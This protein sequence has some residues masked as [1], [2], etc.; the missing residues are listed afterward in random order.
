MTRQYDAWPAPAINN[1]KSYVTGVKEDKVPEKQ[2][3]N[4]KLCVDCKH[5]GFHIDGPVC[6]V[7]D[8]ILGEVSLVNGKKSWKGNKKCES[9]RPKHCRGDWYESKP[10]PTPLWRKI[11]LSE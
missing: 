8:E 11:F 2:D 1:A 7:V 3:E 4:P 10:K 6:R 9:V 5:K